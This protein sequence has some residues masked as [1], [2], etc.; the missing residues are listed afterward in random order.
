M[1]VHHEDM[2]ATD[3]SASLG[4]PATIPKFMP[5]QP[6]VAWKNGKHYWFEPTRITVAQAWPGL[7]V[8]QRTAAK[9]W[10]GLRFWAHEA[11]L[12]DPCSMAREIDELERGLQSGATLV[13]ALPAPKADIA[14]LMQLK[15]V[16]SLVNTIPS[17]VLDRTVRFQDRRWHLLCLQS[18]VPGAG[19]LLDSSPAL[20][21]MLAN[22]WVFRGGIGKND[23][24]RVAR[25]WVGKRQRDILGWLG[26]ESSDSSRR[27]IARI[28][29]ELVNV[30]T[31]LYLRNALQCDE[32]KKAM[33]HLPRFTADTLRIVTDQA[34]LSRVTPSFLQEVSEHPATTIPLLAWALGRFVSIEKSLKP[35]M[36][37]K[38]A[39]LDQFRLLEELQRI[40][41]GMQLEESYLFGKATRPLDDELVFP[42]PPW[43]GVS[44]IEPITDMASMRRE[45]EEM[46]N[47][48]GTCGQ[49]VLSGALYLYKVSQPVRATLALRHVIGAWTLG[50]IRGP[51]NKRVDADHQEAIRSRL[52]GLFGTS[53]SRPSHRGRLNA[54]DIGS[55]RNG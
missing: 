7:R 34:L 27:I 29:A 55:A 24:A 5:W 11:M 37:R 14:R 6:G 26:F 47:C 38:L 25:R 21:W 31:L 1:A 17:A 49:D 43:P 9:P 13:P 36:P 35:R 3:P 19:D 4:N 8:W 20:G 41:M 46:R 18:R 10:I 12:S 23:P 15:T 16:L 50:Q 2:Q 22:H 30:R 42:L 32:Q 54:N 40:N 48:A 53:G 44:G 33:Q 52:G 39:S 51:R 45:G 28:P